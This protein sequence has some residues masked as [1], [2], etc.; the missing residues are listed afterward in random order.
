METP[1]RKPGRPRASQRTLPLV[2]DA[3][4]NLDQLEVAIPEATART[5]TEYTDWVRQCRNMTAE[6][7]TTVMVDYALREVFRRDWLWR[8]RRRA[9]KR[10]RRLD[11]Q[12]R[13][14]AA[15]FLL[16][17]LN[18]DPQRA[19]RARRH[20]QRTRLVFRLPLASHEG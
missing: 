13:Q 19:S 16:P 10:R 20:A 8:N 3:D 5:L 1:R 7:A 4:R 15:P 18:R 14:P 6:E 12:L 9:S 17:C 2:L 11:R